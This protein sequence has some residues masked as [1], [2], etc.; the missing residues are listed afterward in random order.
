M[1]RTVGLAVAMGNG[2]PELKE[3]ADYVT[4][5]NDEDGAAKAIERFVLK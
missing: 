2:H 1:L 4:E 5:T 3:I